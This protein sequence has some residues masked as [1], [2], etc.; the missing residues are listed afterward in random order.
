MTFNSI[1]FFLFLPIVLG[2]YYVLNRKA[3][4][5]MLLVASYVFYGWWDW[6]F[7]GLLALSTV[8][9]YWAALQIDRAS[10][11]GRR[12]RFLMVTLGSNLTILGFF[13]YF[14]FFADSAY[15]LIRSL[16]LEASMPVLQIVLPVGI[17]FYTFQTMSY[18]IDV[19][20]GQMRASQSFLDFALF[21]SYFPQLVAGPIERATS[22]LPQLERDRRVSWQHLREGCLLVFLGLFKKVAVADALAPLIEVPALVCSAGLGMALA[23]ARVLVRTAVEQPPA[24]QLLVVEVGVGAAFYMVFLLF[25]RFEEVRTLVDETLADVAPSLAQVVKTGSRGP[26]YRAQPAKAVGAHESNL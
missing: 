12:R 15:Q 2:L 20:R 25:S 18:T 8:I 19:Y 21:I 9:D 5:V 14:N 7:L 10:D 17:S 23:A 13:K 11:Q 3:Q 24:W 26:L 1:T 16:G 4:N 22:L 6:R